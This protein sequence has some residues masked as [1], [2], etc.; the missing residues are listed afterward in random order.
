M[1][2]NYAWSATTLQ[3]CPPTE[4][5][6]KVFDRELLGIICALCH[7]SHLLRGTPIPI[8]IWTDHC[9]LTY[10]CEP[11]KVGPYAATWQVK[12]Q[13]YNYKLYHKLGETMKA[14]ALSRCPNFNTRNSSN[15]HLLVLPRDCFLG[16][17]H[18][19]L[20][21]LPIPPTLSLTILRIKDEGFNANHLEAKVKLY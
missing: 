14:D 4:Q 2:R 10:W 20:Q 18:S 15:E 5:N 6:Y 8:I 9:N 19:M 1:T 3:P 12:L 16:M 17:P 13:Q 11:Y 7:W 21:A